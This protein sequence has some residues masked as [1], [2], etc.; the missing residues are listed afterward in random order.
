MAFDTTT[1]AHGDV[2]DN[3]LNRGCFGPML[4]GLVTV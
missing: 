2:I 1:Q 4:S 3:I